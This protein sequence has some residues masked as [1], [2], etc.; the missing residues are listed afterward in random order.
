MQADSDTLQQKHLSNPD[1]HVT[2]TGM[3]GL[4][5]VIWGKGQARYPWASPQPQNHTEM[6]S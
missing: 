1:T 5:G 2:G 6:D 3:E 4:Q